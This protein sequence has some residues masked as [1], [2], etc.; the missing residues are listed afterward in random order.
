MVTEY[1]FLIIV[2]VSRSSLPCCDPARTVFADDVE[3]ATR[4]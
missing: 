2:T 4:E 3:E 1:A